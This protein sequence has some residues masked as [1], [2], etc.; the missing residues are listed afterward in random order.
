MV[1][2]FGGNGTLPVHP[3]YI[4]DP[5]GFPRVG[6]PVRE[7]GRRKRKDRR[8]VGMRGP[9]TENGREREEFG[10]GEREG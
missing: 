5:L 9:V 1:N 7:G 10:K 2:T 3:R 8:L 4:T 6:G